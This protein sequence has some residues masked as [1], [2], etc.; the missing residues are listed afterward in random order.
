MLIVSELGEAL[1]AHRM[2][3][4]VK[5]EHLQDATDHYVKSS[6][7][8]KLYYK[9]IIKGSVEEELADVLI[10][11]LDLCGYEK[12]DIQ[13]HVELKMLYNSMRPYKHGKE[14]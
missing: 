4:R 1:E 14:Y 11:L 3:E 13:K 12:I 5:K 8:F 2:N 9:R 7:H 10:R 6:D